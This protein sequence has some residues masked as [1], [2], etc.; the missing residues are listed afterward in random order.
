MVTWVV[1]DKGPLNGLDAHV[2]YTH[3]STRTQ[4]DGWFWFWV[5]YFSHRSARVR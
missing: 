2:Y 4:L 3:E 5:E 1:L